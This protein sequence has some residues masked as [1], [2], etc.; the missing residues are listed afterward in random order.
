MMQSPAEEKGYLPP[1][2]PFLQKKLGSEREVMVLAGPD[3]CLVA[4]VLCIGW[5]FGRG[6]QNF[7]QV[8]P[9]LATSLSVPSCVCD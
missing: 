6:L 1:N 3:A 5:L 2:K 9:R 7:K 8:C 4:T